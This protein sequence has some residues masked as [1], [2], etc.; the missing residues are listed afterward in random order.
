MEISVI[1]ATYNQEATLP[2]TLDSILSQKCSVPYEILIADDCSTD[3]TEVV[4]RRYAEKYPDKVRYIRRPSNLG[5]VRNY[6]TAI[7]E[8]R[9]KFIADCA[10]DDF[11]IDPTKL[12]R[13]FDILN[14]DSEITLVHTA[15]QCYNPLN[16]SISKPHFNSGDYPDWFSPVISGSKLIV[17]IVAHK[18]SPLVHLCTAMYQRDIVLQAMKN[19]PELFESPWLKCEDL[20]ITALMAHDGK[21]AYL[22]QITLNYT[23]L[24]GTESQQTDPEKA[25][26]FYY[27][28]FRLVQLL[29]DI[30]S[31]PAEKLNEYYTNS[32]LFL[33]KLMFNTGD[34][35]LRSLTSELLKQSS[36]SDNIYMLLSAN[37]MV[38][39][40]TLQV[41]HLLKRVLK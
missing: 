14:S 18:L 31:I 29:Q 38:W 11:W 30:C 23:V 25:F 41:K 5:L 21:I 34:T 7:C 22:P 40:T 12:Q 28:S 33:S 8:A 13:Q 4:G 37:K 39:H 35:S 20:Q 10:G 3:S 27:S 6:F 36:A 26:R 19:H 2:R 32:A 15:W 17:P 1:V 24:P 9:G 16:N